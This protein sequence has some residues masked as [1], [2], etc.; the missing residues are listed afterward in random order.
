MVEIHPVLNQNVLQGFAR[1][2]NSVLNVID[3]SVNPGGALKT[4]AGELDGNVSNGLKITISSGV[5]GCA[6]IL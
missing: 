2:E 6:V 1:P 5:G 3:D 4:A